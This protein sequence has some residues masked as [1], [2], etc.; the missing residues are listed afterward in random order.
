MQPGDPCFQCWHF[1]QCG[2]R[3]WRCGRGLSQPL[4]CCHQPGCREVTQQQLPVIR[5]HTCAYAG[6]LCLCKRRHDDCDRC[7][8][9]SAWSVCVCVWSVLC[10][11]RQWCCASHSAHQGSA[12]VPCSPCKGYA[13][14]CVLALYCMCACGLILF[15]SLLFLSGGSAHTRTSVC[16][17]IMASCNAR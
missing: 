12:V 9:R 16:L 8:C 2:T 4:H 11:S 7:L 15:T 3:R 17:H 14:A 13:T 1:Q 10:V 6:V 5:L